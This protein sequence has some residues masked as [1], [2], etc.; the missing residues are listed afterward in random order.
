MILEYPPNTLLNDAPTSDILW[1][2]IY[3]LIGG[4]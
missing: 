3:M 1:V 2:I 4:G